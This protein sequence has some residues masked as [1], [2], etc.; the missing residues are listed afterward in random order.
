MSEYP[1][2]KT[3]ASLREESIITFDQVSLAFQQK[4]V[5]SGLSM[6]I[7]PGSK[8]A[9]LGQSGLGKSSILKLVSNIYQPT[10][11]SVINQ[12]KSIGYVFQEPRL[13]PWLTVYQN[14]WQVMKAKGFEEHF[15]K[16]RIERLLAQVGLEHDCYSLYPH[17]L[18]GGMAQRV[19]LVRAFAIEPDLLLLDEP[20]SALDRQLT[21]QLTEL[22]STLL[23][24]EISMIYV[25]HQV[26][27]VIGSTDLALVLKHNNDFDWHSISNQC[28]QEYF[29]TQLYSNEVF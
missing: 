14:I 10:T 19:S 21:Q 11:G 15:S 16:Q 18:S 9:L 24:D 6:N 28:E 17:E 26:E 2:N 7:A 1:V 13:L 23:T 3:P 20:F 29:L 5:F 27:Q 22:L 12:A 8:V 4:T 25:S